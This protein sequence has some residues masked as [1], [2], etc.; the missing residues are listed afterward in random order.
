MAANIGKTKFI[1]FRT[2]NMIVNPNDAVVLYNNNEIGQ[3][4]NPDMIFALERVSNNSPAK[5]Y[6]LLGVLFDEFLSFDQ[7]IQWAQYY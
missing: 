1:V 5:N 2:R 7:H 6:K 4:E 3:P